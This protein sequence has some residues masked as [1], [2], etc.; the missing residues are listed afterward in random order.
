MGGQDVRLG[1]CRQLVCGLVHL[2]SIILTTLHT[3]GTHFC[4]FNIR[5]LH[6]MRGLLAA[7][8]DVLWRACIVA[9]AAHYLRSAIE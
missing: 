8:L 3:V 6:A 1:D 5:C 4:S 7:L 2:D 9:I